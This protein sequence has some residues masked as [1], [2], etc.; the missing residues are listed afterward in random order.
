MSSE[1]DEFITINCPI[2]RLP[3]TIL[4]I[5]DV[6]VPDEIPPPVNLPPE[7]FSAERVFL[8]LFD[9]F[10][11]FEC[12]Y[13]KPK[14]LIEI[15]DVLLLIETKKPYT[16]H[17]LRSLF[18]ADKENF[19]LISY[20]QE[21]NRTSCM[22]GRPEDLEYA[23]NSEKKESKT[24]TD[25][26]INA[27]KSLNRYDFLWLHFVDFEDIYWRYSFQPPADVMQKLINRTDKWIQLLHN[28]SRPNTL[29]IVAGT[30]GRQEIDLKLEGR[31]A[32]WKRAN[33]PIAF[34]NK[35]S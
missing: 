11:L 26:Y 9:N 3:A 8:A 6:P 21:N 18:F 19:H 25:V 5:L 20:L 13:F 12:T 33:L 35:K 28:Q 24:D 7:Y 2:Q 29:L 34:L 31:A 10:G 22:I 23:E 14:W 17:F 27:V 32:Q 4:S 15:F 16:D 30:H 1:E